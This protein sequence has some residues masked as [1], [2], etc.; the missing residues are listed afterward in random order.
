MRVTNSED[1]AIHPIPRVMRCGTVR[2]GKVR[3]EALTGLRTGQPLSR[4]S[5]KVLGTDAVRRSGKQHDLVRYRKYHIDLAW[6]KN[7]ACSYIPAWEPGGS[8]A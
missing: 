1:I 4:E 8:P 5:F 2:C 3:R 7:L 6:S